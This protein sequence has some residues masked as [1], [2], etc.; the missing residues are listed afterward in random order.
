MRQDS[1]EFRLANTARDRRPRFVLAILFDV[2]SIYCTSHTGIAGVPGI[3]LERSVQN[4]SAVSQRLVPD[5]GRAEIGA[6]DFEI[7]DLASAFTDEIR[8]KLD[9]GLGLR[10]RTVQLWKGYEGQP[11]SSFVLD[12]TQTVVDCEYSSGVYSVRCQDITRSQRKDIFEPKKTTLRASVSATDTTIPVYNTTDFLTIVHGSSWTDAP[13]QT[14]GYI[15]IGD[16]WIRWT[17]KTADSFTGCTRGVLNTVAVEHVVDAATAAERRATVEEV[18]YLELPAVKLAYAVLTGTLYGSANVLPPHWHLGISPSL[19]RAADFTGIGADL[20]VPSDD[21]AGIVLRFEGLKKQDAKRFLEREIYLFLGVYSPVYADGALGLRRM[22]AITQ[23]AAPV[24]TLTEREIVTLGQLQHDFSSIHNRFRIDWS[25]NGERFA[26]S[27]VFID[28]DS[29][30][31]HGEA[32]IETYEFR[33]VV[34]GRHTDSMVMQRLDAIRDRYAEPPQRISVT[35]FGSL[36]ALEVGDVVRLNVANLRDF[37]GSSATIDRAFEIQQKRPDYVRGTVVLDLFGS[38]L[39]PSARPPTSG[40]V[41]PLPDAFYNSAGVALSTLVSMTGNTVNAGTYAINGATTLGAT[42]SIV[43]HLGDLTIPAGVTINITGNVQLRVRGFLTMNGVINGAGG[44][45]PGTSDP[46]GV[47]TVPTQ[48]NPGYVGHSRGGDGVNYEAELFGRVRRRY[49]SSYPAAL[50]RAQ[51]DAF[52]LLQLQVS[53]TALLGLPDDLR[54]TGGGPGGRV[55]GPVSGT[56]AGVGTPGAAGGAGLAIICRGM[57]FGASSSINLSGLSP[58]APAAIDPPDIWRFYPGAGGAGGPGALLILLDG[59][60]L[61]VPNVEGRFV[62]NT[63]T[64]PLQGTPLPQPGRVAYTV[65]DIP[66]DAIIGGYPDPAVISG[67]SLSEAARRIQYVPE[68]QAVTPDAESPPPPATALSALAG[69]AFI[70]YVAGLPSFD[71]FDVVEYWVSIDNNRANAVLAGEGRVSEWRYTSPPTEDRWGWV[72]TRRTINGRRYFS[73]WFPVSATAGVQQ[74]ASALGSGPPGPAGEDGADGAPAVAVFLSASA[75]TFRY[76][77]DGNPSPAGQVITLTAFRVNI[78]TSATWITNPG[79]ITLGGA[80]DVRTLSI[81]DFGSNNAVRIRA[82][83]DGYFDEVTIVR[84]RDGSQAL[85]G[86]LD[87]EAHVLPANSSGS[88]LSYAGASGVFRVFYGFDDVTATATFSVVA[89]PQSLTISGPAAGTGAYSITG[90]FDAGESIATVTFRATVGAL[91]V[92]RV[93][94]LSKS[95]Q[96]VPGSPGA[97][98]ADGDDGAPGAPGPPLF[99]LVLNG[100]VQTGNTLT[101]G[102]VADGWN[103]SA[104]SVQAYRACFAT[105]RAGALARAVMFGLNTDPATDSNYTSIDFAWYFNQSNLCEIYESGSLVGGFGAYTTATVLSITYD[106]RRIQ[107]LKDGVVVRTV[108]RPGLTLAF[109]SSFFDNGAASLADVAF[110]PQGP[111]APPS[112]NMLDLDQWVIGAVPDSPLGNFIP[113]NNTSGESAVVLA[114]Q[115][116]APLGPYGTAEPLWECRPGA[117]GDA[118][119][120]FVNSGDIFALDPKRAYRVRAWFRMNATA[121]AEG[122]AAGLYLGCGTSGETRDLG[123]GANANPYFA[124]ANSTQLEANRWYLFAGVIFGEDYTGGLTGVAGAYDPLTGRLVPTVTARAEYRMSVGVQTQAIRAFPYY[125]TNTASRIWISRPAFELMDGREPTIASL[126]VAPDSDNTDRQRIIPDAEVDA[127][128][129]W[130]LFGPTFSATGGTVGG[131]LEFV[132][133][134]TAIPRRE[135]GLRVVAGRT[136]VK[137]TVRTMRRAGSPVLTV[138]LQNCNKANIATIPTGADTGAGVDVRFNVGLQAIDAW[139][140]ATQYV[141]LDYA[142]GSFPYLFVGVSTDAGTTRLDYID[143]DP[144]AAPGTQAAGVTSSASSVTLQDAD[145]GGVRQ[146][147]SASA[148]TFTVP[149]DTSIDAPIGAIVGFLQRNT[150]ALSIAAGAGVTLLSPP[151]RTDTRTLL[152]RYARAAIVKVA[153]NTWSLDGSLAP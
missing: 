129:A 61:S 86:Y 55:M 110:G 79:G 56:L 84:V 2:G 140:E 60:L 80:G 116:A 101:K 15:R 36:D 103:A 97:P 123:G 133:S 3:V 152:G 94:S 17:G 126:L 49:L 122:G 150:G 78:A 91:T 81:G 7:V 22:A 20:W 58:T 145:I 19:I 76:D 99:T 100:V 42:G 114:G 93:F 46:G 138:N 144:V 28:G 95:P 40:A 71:L 113:S 142:N 62:A 18:V 98:G 52:P 87:N 9:N 39:R 67:R 4:P 153:A 134:A 16:E 141:K 1:T 74:A 68:S 108:A 121:Q 72:R 50:T 57:S 119:G 85:V 77:R 120:G 149:P 53:G 96:G 112:G 59:N 109:D 89:N 12:A 43:Y 131:Y 90:G 65:V 124:I 23:D 111:G 66:E 31:A 30:A 137:V 73:T 92:D 118:S 102:A 136:W 127:A 82:E 147:D 148:G 115:G 38:T 33:G 27:T 143:V 139:V 24:M 41:T 29:V 13:G 130:N 117:S 11:F 64:I 10:G 44:G 5:E 45:K 37:A 51:Y 70:Q 63:G 69:A 8:D 75:L 105:A 106:G 54:G 26:R 6:L 128:A 88:V 104:H 151:N 48:G 47:L 32:P 34:S 83:A 21:T 146:Y 132:G 107:Y 135:R 125:F 25:W 14:C 35:V